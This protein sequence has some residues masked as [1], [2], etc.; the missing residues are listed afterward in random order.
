MHRIAYRRPV[1]GQLRW[2]LKIDNTYTIVAYESL[3]AETEF[4]MALDPAGE[5]LDMLLPGEGAIQSDSLDGITTVTC[6]SSDSSFGI[7]L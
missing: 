2:R 1:G 5:R 4:G 3:E 7:D 6:T